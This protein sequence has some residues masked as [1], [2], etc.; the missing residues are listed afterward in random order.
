MLHMQSLKKERETHKSE[1]LSQGDVVDLLVS[2]QRGSQGTGVGMGVRDFASAFFKS[3]LMFLMCGQDFKSLLS[4]QGF[5]ASAVHWNH[6]GDL[7][8]F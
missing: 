1:D 4:L 2:G 5:S 7:K 8:H 3:P 6:L